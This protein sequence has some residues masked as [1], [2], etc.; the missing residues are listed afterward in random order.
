MDEEFG[1][2]RV[3]GEEGQTLEQ[4]KFISSSKHHGECVFV[5]GTSVQMTS[6]LLF[7]NTIF[8]QRRVPLLS[9]KSL[10]DAEYI[11]M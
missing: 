8:F 1:F 2:L 7:S 5:R 3:K 10:P 11:T 6:A 4:F 9:G